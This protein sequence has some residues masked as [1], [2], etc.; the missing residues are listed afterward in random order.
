LTQSN[1][2]EKLLHTAV[3]FLENAHV[4]N[5]ILD[6]EVLLA[7]TLDTDRLH[8]PLIT[9][10]EIS[11]ER[12]DK[13]FELIKRRC[14][15]E[16]VAYIINKKEFYSEEFYVDAN[17]L[18]PRPETEILVETALEIVS[19]KFNQI[20]PI[21]ILDIGTGSGIISYLLAEFVK[22]AKIIATDI[23]EGALEIAKRNCSNKEFS[24]KIN[25]VKSD[26]YNEFDKE[27]FKKY[28]H[29][30]ISNPPYVSE[31]DYSNLEK[32]IVDFEPHKALI[33]GKTGIEITKKII[34]EGCYFL[35]DNGFFIIEI[36]YNLGDAIK[37]I[38]RDLDKDLSVNLVEDLQNI[39]RVAVIFKR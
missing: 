24:C 22:D 33:G 10:T 21:N 19:E 6:A 7:H 32:D 25:F 37:K 18:I 14:G 28:F 15:H 36:G 17:V 20:S 35:E 38:V 4:G 3:K 27:K 11:K 13:F 31:V 2:I 30:I 29:V 9:F 23:S 34:E 39:E 12:S 1:H 8:L 16:P 26:L 5:P